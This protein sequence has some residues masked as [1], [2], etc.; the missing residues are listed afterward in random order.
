MP[1]VEPTVAI[2]VAPLDQLPVPTG[3][4]SVTD[5]P[6]HTVA[7]P[8]IATGAVVTATVVVA[9]QPVGN[10][11]VTTDMP[12]KVPLT[13]PLDEPTDAKPVLLHRPPGVV[14][15]NV[16]VV[17][18]QNEVVPVMA[19]GGVFTISFSPGV[20]A[21]KPEVVQVTIHL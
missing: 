18:P 4:A 3:F 10:V 6:A 13:I 7:G 5:H 16:V 2:V 1:E 11:Y 14:L 12:A 15:L 9:K 20:V 8:V 19:A 17:P 21:V